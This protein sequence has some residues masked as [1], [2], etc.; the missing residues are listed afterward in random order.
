LLLQ[1][2]I[3]ILNPHLPVSTVHHISWQLSVVT[4]FCHYGIGQYSIQK[5]IY[6]HL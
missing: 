3:D 6:I 5:N 1:L 2:K 4:A